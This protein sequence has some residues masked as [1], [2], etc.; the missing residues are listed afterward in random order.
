MAQPTSPLIIGIAGGSASGKTTIARLLAEALPSLRV[1]TVHMDAYFLPTKP[2]TAAPITGVVYDDYNLPESF[3]L[4]RLLDDL[5]QLRSAADGPQVIIV[6]GLL[7]LHSPDLR[8]RLHL[9]IFVD[10]PSDERIVRRLKRNMA[11]GLSFDEIAAY[12]LDSVRYRHQEYVEPSR[13]HADIVLNGSNTSPR[14][15]ELI[16]DWIRAH[17]P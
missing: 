8:A 13:W 5:D 12:Y 3:D 7:T 4:P 2:R 17:A 14:G 9:R 16:A 11:R 10:L 15:I 6:E 1:E